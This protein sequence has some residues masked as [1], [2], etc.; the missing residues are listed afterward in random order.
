MNFRWRLP[1]VMMAGLVAA[2]AAPSLVLAQVAGTTGGGGQAA[3]PVKKDVGEGETITLTPPNL[4]VGE[5]AQVS[6]NNFPRPTSADE[7]IVVPAGSPDL[8]PGTPQGAGI[9]VLVRIY[10]LNCT[11]YVNRI[12]P[13][14][15]GAYEIRDMT[16]LYNNDNR[17]EIAT[18]TAFSVH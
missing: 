15:P 16:T 1:L 12:G 14:A 13:F 2:G 6:C 3:G 9:R 11:A 17:R 7:L 5:T 10:A 8:D 4:R 18:R